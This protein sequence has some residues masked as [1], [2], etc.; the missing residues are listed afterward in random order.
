M[1]TV[2]R[3]KRVVKTLDAAKA[4]EKTEKR[5]KPFPP[6]PTLLDGTV[7][8]KYT[9]HVSVDVSKQSLP[10]EGM[11]ADWLHWA[12]TASDFY[13]AKAQHAERLCEELEKLTAEEREERRIRQKARE[14]AVKSAEKEEVV[15]IVREKLLDNPED[16]MRDLKD[17]AK[18]A[19]FLAAANAQMAA[20][21]A[22]G[23]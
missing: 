22:Q 21:Q 9:S 12:Q 18:L 17:P 7:S 6:L 23:E 11:F 1:A 15:E 19:A 8:A 2:R 10:P 3:K 16:F 5:R 13:L 20:L 14:N 4:K